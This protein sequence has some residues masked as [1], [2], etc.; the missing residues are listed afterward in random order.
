MGLR[1][2]ER[3]NYK[4]RLLFDRESAHRIR[5]LDAHIRGSVPGVVNP[6]LGMEYGRD[7]PGAGWF[8]RERADRVDPSIRRICGN[9]AF[10]S[11]GRT[12]MGSGEQ[13]GVSH[14]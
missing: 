5:A 7:A 9:R 8:G 1:V 3:A 11:R 12:P 6:F 10:G 4:L 2:S 13:K 14:P